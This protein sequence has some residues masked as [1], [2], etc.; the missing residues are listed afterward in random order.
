[1]NTPQQLTYL[2]SRKEKVIQSR[3]R[4]EGWRAGGQKG[5]AL[6]QLLK[7]QKHVFKAVKDKKARTGMK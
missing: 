4:L 2:C 6:H 3:P 1:M 7:K 5:D